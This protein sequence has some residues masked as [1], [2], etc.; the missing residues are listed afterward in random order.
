QAPRVEI[1]GKGA[2]PIVVVGTTGDAATPLESTRRMAKKLERGILIVVT[3][4]QHTGY[5]ANECVTTAVDQYLID[6]VVPANELT[7]EN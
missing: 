2:G 4:N 3:A 5:G 1:T 6:L 7:C